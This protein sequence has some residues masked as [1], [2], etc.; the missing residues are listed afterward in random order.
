MIQIARRSS[1]VLLDTFRVVAAFIIAIGMSMWLYVN[2][3]DPITIEGAR[4]EFL[5]PN[6]L[7]V[8]ITGVKHHDRCDG[9]WQVLVEGPEGFVTESAL[10]AT[11]RIKVGKFTNI[12]RDVLLHHELPSGTL[13]G[14]MVIVYHCLMDFRHLV[15]FP[16]E[17]GSSL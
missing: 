10:F 4:G 8:Y 6:H 11:G 15:S 13:T 2:Y 1:A 5:P 12:P 3:N 16:I 17:V 7:R 9:Q 14:S